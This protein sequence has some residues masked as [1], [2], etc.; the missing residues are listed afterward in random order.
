MGPDRPLVVWRWESRAFL[1][2]IHFSISLCSFCPALW[3][4]S[5][6]KVLYS[7]IFVCCEKDKG[8][9]V[10][11]FKKKL[12]CLSDTGT[13]FSKQ[14]ERINVSTVGPNHQSCLQRTSYCAL[15]ILSLITAKK[16]LAESAHPHGKL[17]VCTKPRVYWTHCWRSMSKPWNLS[18]VQDKRKQVLGGHVWSTWKLLRFLWNWMTVQ[19]WCFQS[20]F[21]SP[22]PS[23]TIATSAENEPPFHTHW[24]K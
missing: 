14:W 1:F 9:A 24:K 2:H 22:L 6:G 20:T 16:V 21:P 18:A 7:L 4:G 12:I 11:H 5:P 13:E 10:K 3:M 15:V 17:N 8:N 23:A 19:E